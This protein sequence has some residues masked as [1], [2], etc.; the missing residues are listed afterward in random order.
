MA[1]IQFD[2]NYT[3]PRFNNRE[4]PKKGIANWL[5]K[6]GLVKEKKHA[7]YILIAATIIFFAL[8]ISVIFF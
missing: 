1:N 3:N 4:S 7:E 6:I 5:I 8:T 2:E